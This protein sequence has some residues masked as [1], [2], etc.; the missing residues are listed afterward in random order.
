ML[1][2]LGWDLDWTNVK[3]V[4]GKWREMGGG[5]EVWGSTSI[6]KWWEVEPLAMG[7]AVS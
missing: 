4:E 5:K 6:E 1:G 7:G 3:R 2:W